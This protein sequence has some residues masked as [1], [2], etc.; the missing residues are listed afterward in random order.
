M[1]K[2]KIT[3]TCVYADKGETARQIILRSFDLFLQRELTQN[4]WK[5]TSDTVPCMS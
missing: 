3:A 4:N 1:S 5:F 2:T